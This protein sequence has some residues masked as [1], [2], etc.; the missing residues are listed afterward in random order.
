MIWDPFNRR[1]GT[2]HHQ[3]KSLLDWQPVGSKSQ[4]DHA[5]RCHI[6]QDRVSQ[7]GPHTDHVQMIDQ[8]SV[9][10][11]LQ[12]HLLV[13]RHLSVVGHEVHQALKL[14]TADQEQ[15]AVHLDAAVLNFTLSAAENWQMT[16]PSIRRYP[17]QPVM[18][19]NFSHQ[20]NGNPVNSFSPS[21]LR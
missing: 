8:I 21:W 12:L 16:T 14:G 17:L 4:Y 11:M 3:M 13:Q 19:A 7:L 15:S 18:M 2:W 5:E 6:G 10:S 1:G 9:N 20:L